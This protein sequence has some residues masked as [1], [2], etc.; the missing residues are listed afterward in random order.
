M[1]IETPSAPVR[2]DWVT[3]AS[4]VARLSALRQSDLFDERFFLYWEEIELC[5]RISAAGYEIWCI[6]DARVFHSG[7]VSTGMHVSE[8][9]IPPYWFASRNHFFRTTGR[10]GNV[11]LL[12]LSVAA[13]LAVQRIH[14]KLRGQPLTP[15]YYL[16]DFVRHS[17]EKGPQDDQ[18]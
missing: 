5:H 11:T 8:R 3:G 14:R 6:P 12:N 10:G 7:G 15:P 13:S 18:R 4:F 16:R 17:F 9:R 1:A 2:V